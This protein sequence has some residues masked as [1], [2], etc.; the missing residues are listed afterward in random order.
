MTPHQFL[1]RLKEAASGL[2]E[3]DVKRAGI[4][5]LEHL[6]GRSPTMA[7]V[8]SV[9]LTLAGGPRGPVVVDD[10][11]GGFHVRDLMTSTA[12]ANR[13]ERQ[14]RTLRRHLFQGEGIPFTSPREARRWITGTALSEN[15][16]LP[17]ENTAISQASSEWPELLAAED[18][19][20]Q[21]SH[22]TGLE[23][24]VS[25]RIAVTRL[26]YPADPGDDRG[27]ARAP[28]GGKLYQLSKAVERIAERTG[29]L[30]ATITWW[31]LLG[32]K[33]SCLD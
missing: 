16:D 2:P 31:V 14:V 13:F 20:T 3:P 24:E 21:I 8:E 27:E 5:Y 33:P 18:R 25:L 32:V 11:I 19:A 30:A 1:S 23:V 6:T 17:A 28:Y 15:K 12:L 22:A 9:A 4:E 29:F 7:D 26:V 10:P